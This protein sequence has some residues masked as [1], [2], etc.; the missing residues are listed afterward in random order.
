MILAVDKERI[1]DPGSVL[2]PYATNPLPFAL[3]AHALYFLHYASYPPGPKHSC[4]R[5]FRNIQQC[6]SG[7]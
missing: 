1:N 6:L 2:F 4:Q 5:I 3:C 7:W